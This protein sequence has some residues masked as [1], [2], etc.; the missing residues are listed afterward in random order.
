[1]KVVTKHPWCVSSADF[2]QPIGA[3]NDDTTNNEYINTI[4]EHFQGKKISSLELG[5]AGGQIVA[6]L[7]NHGHDA[8]GLEGTPYPLELGRPAWS[9]YYNTRLFH[10]DLSKPFRLLDEQGEDY[11]FDLISHWEF[12]EH[13]PTDCLKYFH[14]KLYLHL[15]D[16]GVVLCGI[17]PWG[18]FTDITQLPVGHPDRSE[19]KLQ[20]YLDDV[21]ARGHAHH[22]SCFFRHQWEAD[23]FSDFFETFDYDLKGKLREDE[24][25]FNCILKKKI[26]EQY[27]NL[28]QRYIEEYE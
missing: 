26:G 4:E 19:E 24:S 15:K 9:Q 14:A 2:L 13:L 1:M 7:I 25:S 27:I 18:A 21:E 28:A 8:Y 20:I 17:C 12:L 11:Q 3:V 16:E 6:D 5:C 10:C 23:Y 22:Q